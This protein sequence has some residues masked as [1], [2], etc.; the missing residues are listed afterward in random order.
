MNV[1]NIQEHIVLRY[2]HEV[3]DQ[4]NVELVA[5]L[6]HPQCVIHR[7]EETL[8][9]LD[10]IRLVAERRKQVFSDYETKI[11]DS[12]G[13]GDRVVVRLTHRALGCGLWRSRL[14]SYDI[15]GKRVDWN[16]TAIFR[17]QNGM[18]IEEWVSRD[19]LGMLLR[20]GFLKADETVK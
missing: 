4:G 20:F 11:H 13:C 15:T 2:F 10:G 9:G 8:F 3:L 5:E 19:E 16:A 18:I 7:L 17:F 6:F 1:H 12:F 14:G